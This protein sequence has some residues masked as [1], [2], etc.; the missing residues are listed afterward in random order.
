MAE[1]NI[2]RG[3]RGTPDFASLSK[4]IIPFSILVVIFSSVGSIFYTIP[5]DAVG[6][7][8]RF[9]KYVRTTNPGLRA[10]LPWRIETVKKIPVTFTFSEEFGFRTKKAGVKTEYYEPQE[11]NARRRFQKLNLLLSL[12]LN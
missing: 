1:I 8:Q 12:V 2:P 9:G 3:G 4:W 10:K 6:V 7:V 5:T 11:Y